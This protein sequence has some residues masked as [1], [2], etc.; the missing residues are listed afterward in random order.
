MKEY[1]VVGQRVIDIDILSGGCERAT[2]VDADAMWD[3]AGWNLWMFIRTDGGSRSATL[4]TADGW[5]F[6]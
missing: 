4:F 1:Q 2:I 5:S 6:R 3:Y